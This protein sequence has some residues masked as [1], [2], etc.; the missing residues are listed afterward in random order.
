VTQAAEALAQR[1]IS[2]LREAARDID[3]DALHRLLE[4]ATDARRLPRRNVFATADHDI[5]RDIEAGGRQ[6]LHGAKKLGQRDS[7]REARH[8]QRDP[9]GGHLVAGAIPCPEQGSERAH[10]GLRRRRAS[11][12]R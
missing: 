1:T 3:P 4:V 9:V 11:R 12:L 7:M 5:L 6:A 8:A 10:Q 2:R